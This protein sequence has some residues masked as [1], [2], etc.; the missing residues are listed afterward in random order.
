M[1]VCVLCWTG[2]MYVTKKFLCFYSNLFG[3][4]K[5]VS[6]GSELRAFNHLACLV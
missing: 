6:G 2:R 5:K 4:E 3:L 1:I